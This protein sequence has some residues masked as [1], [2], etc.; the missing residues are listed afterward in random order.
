M[1]ISLDLAQ[2]VAKRVNKQL[3]DWDIT[4]TVRPKFI[5]MVS[6]VI[7]ELRRE[8]KKARDSK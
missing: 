8:A 7:R 4:M 5:I 2:S 6:L 3:S 1:S